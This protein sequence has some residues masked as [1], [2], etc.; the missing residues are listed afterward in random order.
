MRG[1]E[2]YVRVHDVCRAM[3]R[4]KGTHRFCPRPVQGHDFRFLVAYQRGQPH[5]SS[6]AAPSLREDCGRNHE[7]HSYLARRRQKGDETS[8]VLVERDE[9]AGVED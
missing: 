4:A 3:L 2:R 7:A 5:L 8:V 9:R 6:S 1:N